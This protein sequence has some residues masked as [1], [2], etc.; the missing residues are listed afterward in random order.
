MADKKR[1]RIL[2]ASAGI[3]LL[4]TAAT[5]TAVILTKKAKLERAKSEA[6]ESVN[7]LPDDYSKKPELVAKLKKAK[8]YEDFVAI[9]REAKAILADLAAGKED[10]KKVEEAKAKAIEAINRLGADNNFKAKLID[11]LN[12]GDLKIKDIQNIEKEAEKEYEADRSRRVSE[13]DQTENYLSSL[14]NSIK[15]KSKAAELQDKLDELKNS[16][17]NSKELQADLNKLANIVSDKT[18]SDSLK[19]KIEKAIITPSEEAQAKKAELEKFATSNLE[20]SNSKL[21]ELKEALANAVEN[22]DKNPAAALRKLEEIQ[23]QIEEAIKAEDGEN[24]LLTAKKEMLKERI[25]SSNLSEEA[26]KSE[27]AKIDATRNEKEFD[28]ASTKADAIL[29]AQKQNDIKAVEKEIEAAL[30]ASMTAEEILNVK[31][32][33]LKDKINNSTLLPSEKEK[34]LAEVESSKSL[35]EFNTDKEMIEKQLE[36]EKS[37]ENSQKV[38]DAL[39]SIESSINEQ[40]SSE[41]KDSDKSAF[42][43][44]KEVLVNTIKNSNLP[45]SEKEKLLSEVNSLNNSSEEDLKNLTNKTNKEV[46]FNNAKDEA[47]NIIN[48]LEEPKKSELKEKLNSLSS[49][50][51]NEVQKILAE[52]SNEANTEDKKDALTKARESVSA[53]DASNP[54][55]SEL[56][57]LLENPDSL[58]ISDIENINSQAEL[59]LDS[60]EESQLKQNENEKKLVESLLKDIQNPA[61]KAE[62]QAEL[63]K[64]LNKNSDTSS[65]IEEDLN[66]LADKVKDTDKV[67]KL[68]KAVADAVVTPE[69]KVVAKKA[70]LDKLAE[71]LSSNSSE[72]LKQKLNDVVNN[73][74]LSAKDKEIELAKIQKEIENKIIEE[75]GSN[76][77]ISKQK[78]IANQRIDASKLSDTEKQ[79][80]KDKINAANTLEALSAAEAKLSEVLN[81]QAQKDVKAAEEAIEN[82]IKS[83][84]GSNGDEKL[85]EAKKEVLKEKINAAPNLTDDQREEL[86][87]QVDDAT[88]L[89]QFA[90]N[91]EEIEKVLT[92]ENNKAVAAEVAKELEKISKQ[93]E[94]ALEAQIGSKGLANKR[95]DD[96]KQSINDSNLPENKKQELIEALN[97]IDSSSEEVFNKINEEKTKINQELDLQSAKDEALA[98]ANRL[99]DSPEKQALLDKI[100]NGTIAN[101]EEAKKAAAEAKRAAETK[102]KTALDEAKG[103]INKLE[104]AESE[105]S[106]LN[107]ELINAST[108]EE[109]NTVKAKAEKLVNDKISE[110]KAEVAKLDDSNPEKQK[111]LD[112]ISEAE[113]NKTSNYSTFNELL[114]QA[115]AEE[116]KE[117]QKKSAK[118]ELASAANLSDE[119]RQRFEREL[120]AAQDADAVIAKKDEIVKQKEYTDSKKSASDETEGIENDAKKAALKSELNQADTKEKAD[121]IRAKALEYK[122]K[123]VANKNKY[124]ELK[125]RVDALKTADKKSEL[126]QQLEAALRDNS[127]NTPNQDQD[128]VKAALDAIISKI[129]TAAQEENRVKENLEIKKQQLETNIAQITD[130]TKRAEYEAELEK[131]KS[132]EDPSAATALA[133]ALET[134]VSTQKAFETKKSEAQAVIN[135][136]RTMNSAKKAELQRRLDVATT[137]SEA[138]EILNE[139]QTEK[140]REDNEIQTKKAAVNAALAKLQDGSEFKNNLISRKD[141][142]SPSDSDD[143]R[144]VDLS[145][146]DAIV[147]ETN[148]KIAEFKKAAKDA[149]ALTAGLESSGSDQTSH[150][151]L[152]TDVEN[153]D[154]QTEEK[155]KQLKQKAE[156]AVATERNK[157]LEALGQVEGQELSDKKK[158]LQTLINDNTKTI[159]ELKEL[160]TKVNKE[161]EL[162]EKAAEFKA[163]AE[164]IQDPEKRRELLDKINN[165]MN[166]SNEDERTVEKLN[167]INNEITSEQSQQDNARAAAY[168]RAKT[169]IDDLTDAS[170]KAELLG[171]LKKDNEEAPKDDLTVSD[172]QDIERAALAFKNF[173]DRKKEAKD[174]LDSLP[175]GNNVRVTKTEELN[176]LNG[177]DESSIQRINEIKLAAQNEKDLIQNAVNEALQK[178]QRLL[179]HAEYETRKN[180]IN[181]KGTEANEVSK[182]QA[183]GNTADQLATAWID[184]KAK[185]QGFVNQLP[186]GNSVKVRITGLIAGKTEVNQIEKV[187][188]L[189]TDAESEKNKLSAAVQEVKDYIDSQLPSNAKVDNN[190]ASGILSKINIEISALGDDVNEELKIK[191]LKTQIDNEKRL[192]DEA[193]NSARSTYAMLPEGN[194]IKTANATSMAQNYY[195][196]LVNT[197]EKAQS[198]KDAI[199]NENNAIQELIASINEQLND[200]KLKDT[201]PREI[202][203]KK[204]IAGQDVGN[205]VHPK[206]KA[207]FIRLRDELIQLNNNIKE[208]IRLAQEEINKLP[209]NN[210]DR[211]RL[212]N[213][214]NSLDVDHDEI[215][216]I[217]EKIKNVAI[218]KNNEFTI[219]YSLIETSLQALPETN[220]RRIEINELITTEG[221]KLSNALLR[222]I[223]DLEE[224]NTELT[225]LKSD[226]DN[227]LQEALNDVDNRLPD[228]NDFRITLEERLNNK[229]ADADTVDEINNLRATIAVEESS[230]NVA[231]QALNTKLED[232]PLDNGFRIE[233]KQIADISLKD[234]TVLNNVQD[235]ND[236]TDSIAAEIAK[237]D[238]TRMELE[239]GKPVGDESYN[240]ISFNL[241]EDKTSDSDN[242]TWADTSRNIYNVLPSLE[243]NHSY[244]NINTN[245]QDVS[246]TDKVLEGVNTYELYNNG[247]ATGRRYIIHG[248]QA[249]S[250]SLQDSEYVTLRGHSNLKSVRNLSSPLYP[251]SLENIV[252]GRADQGNRWDNWSDYNGN[253]EHNYVTIAKRNEEE[254]IFGKI[255]IYFVFGGYSANGFQTSIPKETRISTS[256]DGVTWTNVQNQDYAFDTD[257]FSRVNNTN[258]TVNPNDLKRETGA[259]QGTGN[260]NVSFNVLSVKIKFN[261]VKAKYVRVS[262]VPAIDTTKRTGTGKQLIGFTDMIL[263]TIRN[264]TE[265]GAYRTVYPSLF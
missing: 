171:Q 97:N 233:K 161:N 217:N 143:H 16:S 223:S 99:A 227:A 123:E 98:A 243:N 128:A 224:I 30:E 132:N 209:E 193:L 146:L 264:K 81:T 37:K 109:R 263:Y 11:S 136:L 138:Q 94:E 110:A 240:N 49:E 230:L 115:Q 218:Q 72:E 75:K 191:N 59:I 162:E 84:A 164:K 129:D 14:I 176:S 26:K 234:Q 83:Q 242:K 159:T 77:L 258:G 215:N 178:V 33:Q 76:V 139:A 22:A 1:K 238:N 181:A 246:N 27:K 210:S 5:A 73:N 118:A 141:A 4:G 148:N 85:L 135:T 3:L 121:A 177:N 35:S 70:E 195:G 149:I 67:A 104:G 180:Q 248:E 107:S 47:L 36:N 56:E 108:E 192:I 184:E 250:N 257:W 201:H 12:K 256:L 221:N 165:L 154:N 78:E 197:K 117:E 172:I 183:L 6:N 231:I 21:N 126:V 106:N 92:H 45:E 212:Q 17:D 152:N 111:L 214:L 168:T 93:A 18:L 25:D 179:D 150:S 254:D 13:N 206:E 222:E 15:D 199:S 228:R 208:A 216:E 105:A 140:A 170:E 10:P 101:I 229:G 241:N 100:N 249:N 2:A 255:D 82:E 69:E 90:D 63:E 204:L 157:A 65:T 220:P 174:L 113:A 211:V 203:V 235:I 127:T 213:L 29:N 39:A 142:A 167:E 91:K 62:L 198:I 23:K 196:D 182:I 7:A 31:K 134:K 120:E 260:L 133:N 261:P 124:N 68:K 188:Q 190:V 95:I 226:L 112:K 57:K 96:L 52:A 9:A 265:T 173:E 64:V 202:T 122:N 53:L 163:K 119:E 19:E 88:S 66:R 55:K 102:L 8:T 71:A 219:K 89:D 32:D 44:K 145:E 205:E 175:E 247:V 239:F 160:L 156:A 232:L 185:L 40:L 130:Q 43:I 237:V 253:Q 236:I 41:N 60:K 155:L 137:E 61:K 200:E 187:T 252:D 80:E 245:T 79:A 166:N 186:E 46:A 38:K 50:N 194:S 48:T 244:R 125:A 251:D 87:A 24:K 158:A 147:T 153:A 54:K 169:A 189:V 34:L 58:S 144:E 103:A 114:K 207:D 51:A 225:T 262:W 42:D 20:S 151:S 74:E 131:I 28:R 86:L 259:R 116:S